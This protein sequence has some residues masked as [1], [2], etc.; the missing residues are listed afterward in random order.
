MYH[1]LRIPHARAEPTPMPES[2]PQDLIREVAAAL[3]YARWTGAD[4]VDRA[5]S[6][7]MEQPEEP[8]APVRPPPPTRTTPP[9]PG[10]LRTPT[11]QPPTPPTPTL[12]PLP[13][14][15]APLDRATALARL[16][17]RTSGCEKCPH[18]ACRTHVV[19]GTGNVHARLMLV[20]DAPGAQE[21]AAGLPWQG[22]GGALLDKM[23]LAIGLS[24][25]DVWMT[26][27]TLCKPP[28]DT[29]PP[30]RAAIMA[31][32]PYLRTQMETIKPEAVLLLGEAVAPFLFKQDKPLAALRG[33]WS[34]VLDRP[35]LATWP[36]AEL[37]RDPQK[38]R[39]A[40]AD[41]QSVQ[42]KLGLPKVPPRS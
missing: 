11:P 8:V 6:R 42:A 41:L 23:L 18:A 3:R 33:Q 37:L 2:D 39:E 36:V 28:I 4:V 35:T 32:S 1:G 38:K 25:A 13:Q 24:R 5:W 22:E 9:M 7:P 12:A 40:W 15:T 26:T 17:A 29:A 20:G 10:T 30:E 19:H 16:H 27:I 34:T 21:D 31:C 14:V